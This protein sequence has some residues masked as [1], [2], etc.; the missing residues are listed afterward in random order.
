MAME[1]IDFKSP[2]LGLSGPD[3]EIEEPSVSLTS[4]QVL[5]FKA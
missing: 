1:G 5:S 3:T 2:S 4:L